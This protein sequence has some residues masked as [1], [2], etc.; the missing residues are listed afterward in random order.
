VS[1]WLLR[2]YPPSWR[3][4]YGDEL[5]SLIE[6]DSGGAK[7]SLRVM[8]DVIGAGLMQRLRSSGL[9]G[10]EVPPERRARA[11]VLL[12]LSSWTMFVVAGLGFAKTAEH[13][14]TITPH[15]DQGVPA[16]AYDGVLLAAEFGTLAVLLGIVL[17][18]RPLV[19]FL[20]AGGWQQIHRPVLRA[21]GSTGLTVVVLMGVVNWAHHLTE[22]QRNGGDRLYAAAFVAL[23]LCGVASIGLW[24]RTA[25]VTAG[26]LAL[27][28]TA[29]RRETRLATATAVT[30]AVMTVSATIWWTSVYGAPTRMIVMTLVML[31]ATALAATGVFRSV[32][33]LWA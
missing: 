9:A 7:V 22:G 24:T 4:R 6:A 15:A 10:D 33:A 29:L 12:V 18:A 21:L 31:A 13:W 25:V 32:R 28:R 5:V 27:T 23:V 20:R 26:K 8:L 30:M 19:A 11:G 16:A 14:Q 2:A 3:E 17:T 1:A